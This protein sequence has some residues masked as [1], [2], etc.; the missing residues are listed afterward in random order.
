MNKFFNDPKVIASYASALVMLA[1]IVLMFVPFWNYTGTNEDTFQPEERVTSINGYLWFPSDHSGIEDVFNDYEEGGINSLYEL[2][3]MNYDE[4]GYLEDIDANKIAF[5]IGLQILFG[6]FGIVACIWKPKTT[7]FAV[8]PILCGLV[9]IYGYLVV[10][11]LRMGTSAIWIAS[12]VLS[13]LAIVVGALR[14]VFGFKFK[15]EIETLRA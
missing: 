1:I 14:I 2:S 5:P 10:P 9:G 4:N 13:V 7:F 15:D 6:A 12:L 11:A 8:L 3:P